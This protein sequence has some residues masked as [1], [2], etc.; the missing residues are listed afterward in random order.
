MKKKDLKS[1]MVVVDRKGQVGIILLGTSKGDLIGGGGEWDDRQWKYLR[2]IN[3]DL[4]CVDSK[5]ADIIEV[6]GTEYNQIF[7]TFDLTQLHKIW[8]RPVDQIELTIDEIAAKFDI[9]VELVKIKK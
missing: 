4:T 9:P 3:D 1:G 8:E 7:G 2:N 6:Y 5:D